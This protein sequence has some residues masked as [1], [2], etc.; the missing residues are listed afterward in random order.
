MPAYSCCFTSYKKTARERDLYPNSRFKPLSYRYR[1]H[2]PL[3]LQPYDVT[4]PGYILCK[5]FLGD[6]KEQIPVTIFITYMRNKQELKR[7][8]GKQEVDKN[9]RT[10]RD[11]SCNQDS[12][13]LETDR[14]TLW[15]KCPYT[16]EREK[17]EAQSLDRERE[18]K[19]VCKRRSAILL[20]SNNHPSSR[21][22][23]R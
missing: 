21:N 5:S 1:L 15:M 12:Y 14:H 9:G 8:I 20:L 13:T 7:T 17:R 22:Q 4:L 6:K 16:R 19:N 11:I 10:P 3:P 2:S 23:N 18:T